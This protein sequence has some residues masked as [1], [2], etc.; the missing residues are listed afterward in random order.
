M[1]PAYHHL[2]FVVLNKYDRQFQRGDVV[3]FWCDGLS[4]T[5]VKRIAAVPG[6]TVVINNSTL[7][8]NGFSSEVF[9]EQ[10]IFS[11]SGILNEE[12]TLQTGEYL[13]LGDNISKSKDSRYP[14]IGVVSESDIYGRIG[15]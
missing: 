11:Y 7:Y 15:F 13:L 8:V 9:P 3:A 14:E 12:I 5:L 1:A 2:Q 10:N 6:D 4:C